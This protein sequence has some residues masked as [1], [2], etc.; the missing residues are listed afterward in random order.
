MTDSADRRDALETRLARRRLAGARLAAAFEPPGAAEAR[1]ARTLAA[2]D[3]AF[4]PVTTAPGPARRPRRRWLAAA[5]SA[6]LAA[7]V[8]AAAVLFTPRAATAEGVVRRVAA[9]EAA[10]GPR[11]FALTLTLAGGA[12]RTGTLAV[13]G[14]GAFAVELDPVRPRGGGL[15]FGSDGVS[16]W[17]RGPAGFVRRFDRPAAWHADP[18]AADYRVLPAAPADVLAQLGD[19]YALAFGEPIPAGVR[20]V[21]AT[22]RGGPGPARVTLTP[23]S[24]GTR[25]DRLVVEWPAGSPA[26]VRRTEVTAAR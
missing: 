5:G 2:F 8:A 17:V 13:A 19:G 18:A 12:E 7:G 15:A 11:T 4:P 21:I 26:R 24:T 9:A 16:S 23:D 22:N 25:T 6:A 20:P 3:A 14:P 1:V 10:A